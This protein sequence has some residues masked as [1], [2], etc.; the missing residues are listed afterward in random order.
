MLKKVGYIVGFFGDGINDVLVFRKVDVGIFVDIVV[1]IIKDVSLVILL[2]KSL[3]VL[4]DVVMEGCN[5]FGN[6]LK[7]LKMIVSFNF[8]NVFS[9]L[10]VSVFIFF[11]LML[12][13]Y[14]LL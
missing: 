3:I 14:F 13:L 5:V 7:Y 8:G 10:V 1:D 2:E 9:V 6:I 4:N 11:L 12:F